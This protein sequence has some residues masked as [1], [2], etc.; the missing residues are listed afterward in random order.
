MKRLTKLQI[1]FP[2]VAYTYVLVADQ[3]AKR[4]NRLAVFR[5]RKSYS[6]GST[7]DRQVKAGHVR[8]R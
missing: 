8:R 2:R 6:E 7:A 1:K 5:L 4:E 3:D